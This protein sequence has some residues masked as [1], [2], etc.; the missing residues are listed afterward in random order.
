MIFDTGLRWQKYCISQ[1]LSWHKASPG[2]NHRVLIAEI[3]TLINRVLTA[4]HCM[5][6]FLNVILVWITAYCG[7]HEINLL[8]V[9]VNFNIISTA[10]E[11]YIV[12]RNTYYINTMSLF[13]FICKY[14]SLHN[15]V[16]YF[17]WS[18]AMLRQHKSKWCEQYCSD[19]SDPSCPCITAALR[20]G[21]FMCNLFLLPWQ[22]MYMETFITAPVNSWGYFMSNLVIVEK[23]WCSN[24]Q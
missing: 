19:I 24:M 20:D 15:T 1:N 3:L 13:W 18:M 2:V 11:K 16:I 21:R 6:F 5:V 8:C 23:M 9:A 14:I 22:H 4:P 7:M 10:S 12:G 17:I